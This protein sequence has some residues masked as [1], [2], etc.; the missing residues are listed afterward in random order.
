MPVPNS[1]VVFS[2]K[3]N[4]QRLQ[5]HQTLIFFLW[6]LAHV[7][8]I[9]F[10][11]KVCPQ[12]SKKFLVLILFA[13]HCFFFQKYTLTSAHKSPKIYVK[14]SLFRKS[15]THFSSLLNYFAWLKISKQH[16]NK[17]FGWSSLKLNNYL[18]KK[19]FTPCRPVAC[20]I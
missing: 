12:F 20:K 6:I 16:C 11:T 9:A 3:N 10:T 1:D 13:F 17:L 15:R 18:K 4:F 7:K 2:P 19:L 5:L 8:I 14:C